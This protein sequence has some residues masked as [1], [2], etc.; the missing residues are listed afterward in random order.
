[1]KPILHF[2]SAI[3]LLAILPVSAAETGSSASGNTSFNVADRLA[4]TNLFGAMIYGLDEKLLDQII[5]T[6]APEFEA[7]YLIPGV[8]VQKVTGRAEFEKMMSRRFDNFKAD[9]IQRRHIITAPYFLEQTA[10]SAHV[11]IHILNCTM[12]NHENWHPFVSAI[13]EFRAIKRDGVWAFI[14]QIETVDTRMDMP[15]SK[16]LPMSSPQK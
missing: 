6:L 2:V 9:G 13:G 7:E 1:M 11:V 15:L 8:P 12:K 14:H 3:F 10:D 4:I 16:V 5:G